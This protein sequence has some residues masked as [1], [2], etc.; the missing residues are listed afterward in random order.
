MKFFSLIHL[1]WNF[2]FYVTKKN[3]LSSA[4]PQLIKGL[5][6]EHWIRIS[7]YSYVLYTRLFV[8]HVIRKMS[9]LDHIHH[10]E[11]KKALS[12]LF[13]CLPFFLFRQNFDI[14]KIESAF[15]RNE[16]IFVKYEFYGCCSAFWWIDVAC[17]EAFWFTICDYSLGIGS[18]LV[19]K[20]KVCDIQ[21]AVNWCWIMTTTVRSVARRVLHW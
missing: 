6:C 1:L 19:C 12:L 2:V 13:S 17:Y 16:W 21:T 7:A 14:W 5:L 18:N 11:N 9:H 4:S 10:H 15:L 20:L 8:N 3:L